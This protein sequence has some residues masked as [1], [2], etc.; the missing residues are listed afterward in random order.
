VR[1]ADRSAPPPNPRAAAP[2]PAWV[3]LFGALVP[4]AGR[5]DE[6][7]AR[8]RLRLEG[9]AAVVDEIW[10]Q[11]ATHDAYLDTRDPNTQA[12][13]RQCR[14]RVMQLDEEAERLREVVRLLSRL[15]DG[16]IHL[17]TRWFLPDK[18]APPLPLTGPNPLYT[19]P[20]RVQRLHRDAYVQLEWPAANG[21]TTTQ[22]CRI[23]EVDGALIRHGSG[24]ALL[25]GPQ[26][27][28]VELLVERP[29]GTRAARRFRRTEPVVPPRH[30]APTT[31]VVVR[32]PNGQTRVEERE[33]A[34]EARR[35]AGN[36]GYIRIAHLTKAQVILDF[37]AALDELMETDGLLL[38]LRN[39]HGG[40]P[41]IMAPIAGRFFDRCVRVC[42]FDCRTPLVGALARLLG[43]GGVFPVPPCYRKPLVVLIN[44]GTG[45][46]S[47]GLAFT[48]GDTGRALLVGRPTRGLGAAIR[49]VT[50]SN[51]LVL[52]HS[53]VRVQRIGRGSYQSVGVQPHET[54]EVPREEALA[55]GVH[56]A[57]IEER[58]RQFQHALRRLRERVEESRPAGG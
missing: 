10:R 41:W 14:E 56:Q 35:L 7:D 42:S 6:P 53:W 8:A 17:T 24:W 27:S 55:L 51:G 40:Y 12:L 57:A 47:E 49:N 44:D 45:S 33:V 50:L 52:W 9:R 26:G 29:D 5:A 48:L 19:V 13:F 58:E 3:L 11:L 4:A 15:G 20:L 16:H 37:H 54:V 39:A 38:D 23:L 25:N 46:M 43:R 28:E 36:F 34:I 1:P 2:G 21:S 18:P 22:D 31:Q 30:F 32:D